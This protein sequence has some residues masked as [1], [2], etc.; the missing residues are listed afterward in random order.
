[1]TRGKRVTP[2][3]SGAVSTPAPSRDQGRGATVYRTEYKQEW[4]ASGR[5]MDIADI[6][7]QIVNLGWTLVSVTFGEY[8]YTP[9]GGGQTKHCEDGWLLLFSRGRFPD[10]EPSES[11]G[12]HG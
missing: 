12:A 3:Q 11:A 1:M 4:V 7:T 9:R 5:T 8:V 6:V 2:A 10:V